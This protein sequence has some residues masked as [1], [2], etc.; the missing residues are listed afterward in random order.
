MNQYCASVAGDGSVKPEIQSF[1]EKFYWISDTPEA[2]EEYSQQF[3]KG[4]KLIMASREA[5]G[6]E[7][8]FKFS[9]LTMRQFEYI[10]THCNI[11]FFI[12]IFEIWLKSGFRNPQDTYGN[13]GEDSQAFTQTS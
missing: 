7:G 12:C 13:V 8:A 11:I 4:G 10:L 2:H 5:N 1:F 9:M 6:R 3:T